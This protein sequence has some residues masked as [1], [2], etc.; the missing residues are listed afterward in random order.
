[1]LLVAIYCTCSIALMFLA[2]FGDQVWT[3]YSS[4]G[5]TSAEQ[6][7]REMLGVSHSNVSRMKSS[8]LLAL[9]TAA[10]TYTRGFS[11]F[12]TMSPRAFVAMTWGVEHEY[13]F[14]LATAR[15]EDEFDPQCMCWFLEVFRIIA[16]LAAHSTFCSRSDWLISKL[17]VF[18]PTFAN[19]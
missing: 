2:L 8:I 13:R 6:T 19:R 17:L 10:S 4:G 11:V 12:W 14:G 9:A 5:Q 16:F 18:P 1:M 7:G 3:Q 15:S